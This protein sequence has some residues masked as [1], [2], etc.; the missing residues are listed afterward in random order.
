[1][2]SAK[3][4]QIP[5]LLHLH[6]PVSIQVVASHFYQGSRLR[7]FQEASC[8]ARASE[9]SAAVSVTVTQDVN[10]N[11]NTRD[12]DATAST[13]WHALTAAQETELAR[14]L[15]HRGIALTPTTCFQKK[16]MTTPT[17]CVDLDL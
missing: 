13:P 15:D 4:A 5:W 11:V 14:P 3:M 2:I 7:F 1:M 8:A 10:V 16:R 6:E 17:C 9:E 12:S